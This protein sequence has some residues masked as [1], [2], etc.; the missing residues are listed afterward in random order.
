[1]AS[2][3]PFAPPNVLKSVVLLAVAHR[4]DI[5]LQH[6]YADLLTSRGVEGLITIDTS[7]DE[8]PIVPTVAVAGH[9]RVENVTNI[10]FT[11]LKP[12]PGRCVRNAFTGGPIF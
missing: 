12:S 3:S 1:M 7:V 9:R 5:F 4:H 6:S 8:P 10:E 2:A 11:G